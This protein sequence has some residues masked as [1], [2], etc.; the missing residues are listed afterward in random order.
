MSEVE[1]LYDPT[2]NPRYLAQE[3]PDEPTPVDAQT[4]ADLH[5]DLATLSDILETTGTDGWAHI[6]E[7]I[8]RQMHDAE[9][10]TQTADS[11]PEIHRAQGAI[12]ACRWLLELP[13]QMGRERDRIARA[14]AGSVLAEE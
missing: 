1:V 13:N 7:R 12:R 14:I 3:A 11:L 5:V 4:W 8:R 9:R 2:E 10:A 6:A